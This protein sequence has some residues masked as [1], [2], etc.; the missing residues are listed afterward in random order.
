MLVFMKNK[1]IGK[2]GESAM[3]SYLASQNYRIFNRNFSSRY[4]EIDIIAIDMSASPPELVFIE[5]KS[6][7]NDFFGAP[8]EA[9]DF[10][11]RQKILK[12][13]LYFLDSSSRKLPSVWRID[14]IAVELNH[15]GKFLNLEHFKNIFDGN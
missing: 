6:R 13:A 9:V 14:V 8:Q 3:E 15:A 7:S 10:R 4:G 12:T 5:V 11:K 1:E 2:L